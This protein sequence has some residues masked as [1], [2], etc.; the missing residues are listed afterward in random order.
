MPKFKPVITHIIRIFLGLVFIFS[1]IVKMG[2]IESFQDAVILFNVL[3]YSLILF[4]VIL[5]PAVE[6][7]CGVCLISNIFKRISSVILTILLT[8]FI[9]AISINLAKGNL[10]EC[11]CFG[12]LNIFEKISLMSIIFD[13]V[14]ICGLF[15]IFIN[16]NKNE[17]IIENLKL[18]GFFSI[19][20][21]LYIN[22]QLENIKLENGLNRTR[23]KNI[24]FERALE[25][26][27]NNGAIFIDARDENSYLNKHIEGAI[28]IPAFEYRKYQKN[29]VHVDKNTPLMV[30][31]YHR[32]CDSSL[33]VGVSLLKEGFKTVFNVNEGV[34]I[35]GK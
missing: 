3:P 23:I 15:L 31:C 25:L 9:F 4:V 1:G 32:H 29:L 30:Y 27:N 7:V 19:Y 6:I 11:G 10:I 12:S 34:T 20:L 26:S 21:A 33:K 35:W 8:I 14:L 17:H 28:L 13:L 18:V 22:I 16:S 5:I 2:D 24:S